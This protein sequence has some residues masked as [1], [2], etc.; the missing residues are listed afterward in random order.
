MLNYRKIEPADDKQIAKII[1]YNLEK[2]HL[3]LPGTAY[4]DP[5]LDRLS[6]YYNTK[7]DKRA[8]FVALGDA[9]EVVGGVGVAEFDGIENC[10]ELQKLYLSDSVKGRGCG[11]ELVKLAEESAR[12]LGYQKLY[13]ETHSSLKAAVRLYEKLGYNQVEKPC[14]T[15]HG[16]MNLFY[17][18]Q[19]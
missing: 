11:K 10:A 2:V 16:T 6:S 1:R 7:P 4:F 3:N 15:E 8:Y 19:L 12:A 18:K 5:E 9:G 14:P 17:L 13:L